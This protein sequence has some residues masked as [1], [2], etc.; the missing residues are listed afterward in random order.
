MD[1]VRQIGAR[2]VHSRSG[3]YEPTRNA[4]SKRGLIMPRQG[5]TWTTAVVRS[6]IT[7]VGLDLLESWTN[8]LRIGSPPGAGQLGQ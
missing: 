7:Q 1:E 2:L 3:H 5:K 8:P 4:G 6:R